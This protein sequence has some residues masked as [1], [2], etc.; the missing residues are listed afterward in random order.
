MHIWVK[1]MKNL[2]LLGS[3][4]ALSLASTSA[5]A[6]SVDWSGTYRMEYTEVSMPYL[7]G[8]PAGQNPDRG[9][10]SYFLNHLN[11]SPKIIAMDGLNVVANMEVFPSSNYPGSQVG[12]DFGAGSSAY[13]PSQPYS[14]AGPS[15]DISQSQGVN[16]LEVNQVYMT[17]N[18]EY[19]ELVAGRMP[20]QF[21]LGISHNAGNG[22]FD[23]W[24]ETHDIVGYKFIVGNL[25]VMPM[26][27][28][29]HRTYGFATGGY[30]SEGM[31]D[32]NYTNPETE[33]TFAIFHQIRSAGPT[34][35][36]SAL[37]FAP[38]ENTPGTIP[39]TVGGLNTTL[40]SLYIARGW[41][42]FKFKMEAAFQSGNTGAQYNSYLPEAGVTPVSAN[43]STI[44]LSGYGVAIEL[45]FPRPE[46]S[47]QWKVR[48]G[49][50]SGDNPQ[51]Q[52]FEGFFFNRNYN[53]AMLLFNHPLGANNYDVL[54]THLGRQRN[55]ANQVYSNDQTVDED[56]LSNAEY[57]SPTVDYNLNDKW[58]WNNSLT[59]AMTQVNPS[60]K[61][62]NVGN[63][64]GWEYDTG[65]T[66]KPH[67]KFRWI[68]RVGLF[69]PG[70]AWQEGSA[71]RDVNFT[72]GWETKAAIS[73]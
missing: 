45:E 51:T 10:K 25:S 40:T 2:F 46:S 24:L 47:W 62:S 19:G 32:V 52:N 8:I 71:G 26:Y 34:A 55:S 4:V 12:T 13:N 37:F 68:T 38:Y 3:A 54:R 48:T 60:A 66:Y 27:G 7:T 69:L 29:T 9:N 61:Y 67:E 72:Y 44:A 64:L 43:N 70:T 14:S 33:S 5:M 73:F 11:L 18:H 42:R 16:A 50:A 15:G 59:Y 56:M 6:M 63:D 21:G 31:V 1:S 17:W 30:G 41:E 39:L 65:I 28:R 22:L 57:L 20:I 58:T 36:D 49:L 53:L 35:N 23:H